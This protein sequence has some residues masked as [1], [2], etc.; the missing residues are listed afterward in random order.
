MGG[1]VKKSEILD[2]H[3]YQN[4]KQN[5]GEDWPHIHATVKM[6]LLLREIDLPRIEQIQKQEQENLEEQKQKFAKIEQRVHEEM[7]ANRRKHWG[8]RSPDEV[9]DEF[10]KDN[11]RRA[12]KKC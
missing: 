8:I 11:L 9:R 3:V 7:E 4:I 2:I 5:F 6:G 1:K 12:T 10:I